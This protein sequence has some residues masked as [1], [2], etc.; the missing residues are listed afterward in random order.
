VGDLLL[1]HREHDLA[2]HDLAMTQ[3]DG[4][5]ALAEYRTAVRLAP[6]RS[7]HYYR[8]GRAFV[9]LGQPR[10][11]LQAFQQGLAWDPHSTELLAEMAAVQAELG[12]PLGALESDRRIVAIDES[13]AGTVTAL[14]GM[15]DSRPALAHEKL[16]LAALA[17]GRWEE[18]WREFQRAAEILRQRRR[19]QEAAGTEQTLRALGKW[20]A[21]AEK[22]LRAR[23]A[24]LW[25]RVATLATR[26]GQPAPAEEARKLA[27]EARAAMPG[28]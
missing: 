20:D 9:R 11:A 3:R 21:E 24:S 15:R 13:P 22:K 5:A 7:I 27:A 25:E 8:L 10:A 6:T 19:E 16:G 12:D 1:A 23:E 2:Q 4:D 17:E 26:A 14:Q 18:A 28:P